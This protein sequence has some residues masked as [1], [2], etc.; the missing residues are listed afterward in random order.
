MEKLLLLLFFIFPL[1]MIYAAISDLLTMTIP[2][3]ISLVLLIAFGVIVFIEGY[4]FSQIA[5]HISASVLV[6]MICFGFFAAGWM[7]GGDAKLA[8]V[9]SLWFGFDPLL[10]YFLLASVFG[11]GLTLLILWI[12]SF[13]LPSFI[14]NWAWAARLHDKKT[15]IPYGIALSAAALIIYPQ[16]PYWQKIIGQQ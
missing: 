16:L 10:N 14:F 15:G 6:L 3:M 9:I 12:R 5:M 7:G 8:S 11:G 13:P 1:L 4:S 2:N